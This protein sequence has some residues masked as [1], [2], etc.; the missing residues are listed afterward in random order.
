[1]NFFLD[2]SVRLTDDNYEVNEDEGTVEI[3]VERIGQTTED[4]PVSITATEAS[5][6]GARGKK[7]IDCY[8]VYRILY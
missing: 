4:I 1:M 6:V 8:T 2:L 7:G 5:P 3:C